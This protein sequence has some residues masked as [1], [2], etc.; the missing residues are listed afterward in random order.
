M[1]CTVLDL[2]LYL[3]LD[4]PLNL[5]LALAFRVLEALKLPG[6]ITCTGFLGT[7]P[8]VISE[9][10]KNKHMVPVQYGTDTC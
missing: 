10:P 9:T 2:A 3:A 5:A 6:V 4:L 1:F 7:F 8:I